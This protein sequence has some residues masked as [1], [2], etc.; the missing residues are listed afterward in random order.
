MNYKHNP[1]LTEYAKNLRKNMTK[2]EN[3]LWYDFLKN[4]PVRF[5]RQKVIDSYIAD[6]YCHEYSLVIEIDGSQHYSEEGVV[7]DAIRTERLEE[8]NLTVMRIPN[9]L[10][11]KNFK[12]VCYY[13]DGWIREKEG[14]RGFSEP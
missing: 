11:N 8:R 14:E 12:D 6:F 13:I 4:Y 7:K 10:I 3:H 9:K 1:N 2:E 5:L